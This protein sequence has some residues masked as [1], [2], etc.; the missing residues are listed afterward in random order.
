MIKI[1]TPLKK[2]CLGLGVISLIGVSAPVYAIDSNNTTESDV[3][4]NEPM[5]DVVILGDPEPIPTD[6]D[7]M[8]LNV[9]WSNSVYGYYYCKDE[10]RVKVTGWQQINEKWYYFDP[11]SYVMK[12]GW[13][14]YGG[15]W[16][17]LL[18]VT[19]VNR[20]FLSPK[21]GLIGT[22]QTGW[23]RDNGKNY[24][25]NQNGVMQTGWVQDN[26]KWY[27]FNQ[28]GSM[29]TDTAIDGCNIGSDG[30]WMQK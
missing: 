20:K 3:Q 10:S 22:M 21:Y 2:L 17:Y 16:Y 8:N 27:Y 28:D 11:T 7:A 30:A 13:L 24:Y 5:I 14:N 1:D 23:L 4:I 18:D 26:G 15:K 12:R 9:G 25:F 6:G 19:H 29:V